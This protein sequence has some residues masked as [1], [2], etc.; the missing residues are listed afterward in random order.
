MENN[1]QI[2]PLIGRSLFFTSIKNNI[3]DYT[4]PI[5]T[6]L[7][8]FCNSPRAEAS[9]SLFEYLCYKI[10]QKNLKENKVNNEVAIISEKFLSSKNCKINIIKAKSIKKKF[11]L[12]PIRNEI[13]RK[14]NALIFVHLER[15]I[16]QYMNQMNEEPIIAKIISSNVNSEED[17]YILNTTMDRIETAFNFTSPEDIQ[18]EVDSINISDQPNTSVFLLNFI[19]GLATQKS[20][21]DI[22]N[23]IM[24]LYDETSNSNTIG[25]NNYF[26]SF[27]KENTIFN[28]LEKEYKNELEEYFKIKEKKEDNES[29]IKNVKMEQ[30]DND[31]DID[32]EEEALKIIAKENEEIRR[33]MEEQDLFFSLRDKN[34]SEF[35]NKNILGQ[36]KEVEN[37]SD[38]DSEKKSNIN[39]NKN[40][41]SLKLNK[42]AKKIIENNNEIV[43]NYNNIK[44]VDS[45]NDKLKNKNK[46]NEEIK[47]NIKLNKEESID[48][49]NNIKDI[50]N[51]DVKENQNKKCNNNIENLKINDEF[52]IQD[53]DKIDIYEINKTEPNRIVKISENINKTNDNNNSLD[54][55]N[56][57]KT[58]QNKTIDISNNEKIRNYINEN[59]IH[60]IRDSCNSNNSNGSI[61]ERKKLPNYYDQN[62]NKLLNSINNNNCLSHFSKNSST[63]NSSINNENNNSL[64][65]K[66]KTNNNINDINNYNN[67]YIKN[68]NMNQNNFVNCNIISK[69]EE[70]EENN[71]VVN[72]KIYEKKIKK[73]GK[74]N[75]P[76]VQKNIKS[77][78]NEFKEN[79][80]NNIKTN[81][82]DD[83]INNEIN[84]YQ[85]NTII[86][87][88]TSN[89]NTVIN[90]FAIKNNYGPDSKEKSINENN[91]IIK[92]N[93]KEIWNINISN[94]NNINLINN[95]EKD[96]NEYVTSIP[97]DGTINRLSTT[98][99]PNKTITIIKN[100]ENILKSEISESNNTQLIN[101]KINE[102]KDDLE[103][104]IGNKDD[105]EEKIDVN[106]ILNS[107]RSIIHRRTTKTRR[108]KGEN[109]RGKRIGFI[110]DFD[111]DDCALNL[112][113]DLKCGCTGN[114][115]NTCFIF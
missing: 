36:I 8:K 106:L 65:S 89:N 34:Y 95:K 83:I 115:D 6:G 4:L 18:F 45:D 75:L 40:N 104:D 47:E 55:I 92:D 12:I 39:E 79:K 61:Y 87:N 114:V 63:I 111:P 9:P 68:I 44:I 35:N 109:V 60:N 30:A 99:S 23:Y 48:L 2:T 67:T 85:K 25:S 76:L 94:N 69:V 93:K 14:W 31:L 51:D 29:K 21:E 26:I 78:N 80:I 98:R 42:S 33:Q 58:Q 43:N 108:L 70:P 3:F 74:I 86:I 20:N 41:T 56:I 97:D 90:F 102:E 59:N 82:L 1:S 22:M 5:K 28:D 38:D 52:N 54:K 11:I 100:Q 101:K 46:E 103:I 64:N 15:Q 110:K 88:E 105:N 32:S 91:D 81:K 77:N 49:N 96:V 16:M 13:T 27:N 19:E 66:S 7:N 37:E 10:I 24:K 72:N 57:S 113:K 53:E 107:N 17:D 112:S 62:I 84:K 73:K 71:I 50:N